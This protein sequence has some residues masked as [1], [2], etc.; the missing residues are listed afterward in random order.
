MRRAAVIAFVVLA[1][2]SCAREGSRSAATPAPSGAGT[3]QSSGASPGASGAEDPAKA[4][5]VRAAND[6]C[7]DYAADSDKLPDPE[8]LDQYVPFM[9]D[10]IRIGDALQEKLRALPVPPADAKG[11]EGYLNGNDEQSRVLNEALPKI[12]GAAR[13][14]DLAAADEALSDALDR[15]NEISES[16]DPFA[17]SY[18]LTDCANPVDDDG[19]GVAA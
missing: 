3:S 4:A 15:F 7:R 1:L 13:A 10:F 11:I 2:A 17:R 19:S 16:Q 9:K 6:A 14:N 8:E 12:E 18:G 5:F